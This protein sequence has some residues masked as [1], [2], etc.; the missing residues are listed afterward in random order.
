MVDL[1][2]I[3]FAAL[4]SDYRLALVKQKMGLLQQYIKRFPPDLADPAK[5]RRYNAVVEK[6]NQLCEVLEDIDAIGGE[7]LPGDAF[8]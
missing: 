8:S 4:P 3:D 1:L 2:S 6:H 5:V 7:I